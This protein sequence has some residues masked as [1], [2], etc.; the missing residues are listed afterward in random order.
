MNGEVNGT[1]RA[2]M[3]AS[4][5]PPVS[6]KIASEEYNCNESSESHCDNSSEKNNTLKEST[7]NSTTKSNGKQIDEKQDYGDNSFDS[8]NMDQKDSKDPLS[9]HCSDSNE[10]CSNSLESTTN[11]KD[12]SSIKLK[13]KNAHNKQT[14]D[15]TDTNKTEVSLFF[16]R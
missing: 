8:C 10:S 6:N 9:N 15:K 11:N 13:S 1:I 5:D 4:D 12:I 14:C 3:G 16:C 7:E 2:S